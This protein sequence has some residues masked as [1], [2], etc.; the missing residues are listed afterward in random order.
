MIFILHILYAFWASIREFEKKQ[1]LSFEC[2]IQYRKTE[3]LDD[4]KEMI[5]AMANE[6]LSRKEVRRLKAVLFAKID[7]IASRA[8]WL[9]CMFR[10]SKRMLDT[11]I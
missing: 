1:S 8:K 10:F 7:D 6:V 9:G 11:K 3:T 5:A 4:K 2:H